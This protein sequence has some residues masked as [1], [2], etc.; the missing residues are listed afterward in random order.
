MSTSSVALPRS[1][2][3][4]RW[5]TFL[6]LTLLG[7]ALF[8]RGWAYL[9]RSP[10]FIGEVVLVLGI[11]TFAL[12]R[13]ER[14]LLDIPAVWCLLLLVTWG[15]LRTLPDVSRCGTEALRDS[16]IWA[17]SAFAFVVCGAI[18]ADPSR[19]L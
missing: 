8:G 12:C 15:L 7:Y 3:T 17:Y 4:A 1:A 10:I 13:W 2:S 18:L 9:G 5:L 16:V 19:L 14:G 6:C 11:V